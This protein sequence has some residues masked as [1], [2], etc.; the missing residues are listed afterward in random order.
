MRLVKTPGPGAYE[1][2]EYKKRKRIKRKIIPKEAKFN[3]S[4]SLK[5]E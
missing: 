1:A 2:P 4:P 5:K 3:R